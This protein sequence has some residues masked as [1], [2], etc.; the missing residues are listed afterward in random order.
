[1]QCTIFSSMICTVYTVQ[2]CTVRTRIRVQY[3]ISTVYENLRTHS[4]SIYKYNHRKNY[5]IIFHQRFIFVLSSFNLSFIIWSNL[6]FY[7]YIMNNLNFKL[8]VGLI[9]T[10]LILL[11]GISKIFC[12]SVN[13]MIMLI[14]AANKLPKYIRT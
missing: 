5:M 1:M 4:F 9:I 7:M 13:N 12:I 3:S 2:Y 8:I 6:N 10:T 14:L 11:N